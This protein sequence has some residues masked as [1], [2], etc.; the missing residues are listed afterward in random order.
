M[1]LHV[2][3]RK[4]AALVSVTDAL[5][6]VSAAVSRAIDDHALLTSGPVARHDRN[7]RLVLVPL[8]TGV[9]QRARFFFHK[10]QAARSL[11]GHNPAQEKGLV[12]RGTRAIHCR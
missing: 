9:H 4:R 10:R 2:S 8:V 11:P 1:K 7:L 6:N 3:S 5:W 12:V